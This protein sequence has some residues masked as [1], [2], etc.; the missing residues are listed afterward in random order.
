MGAKLAV[1]AR[2]AGLTQVKATRRSYEI[3]RNDRGKKLA[4]RLTLTGATGRLVVIMEA[5][6]VP[7]R[8]R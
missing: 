1:P 8:K 7:K 3:G 4:C 5:I 2:F 6:R